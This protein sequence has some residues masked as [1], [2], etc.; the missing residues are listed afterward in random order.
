V[1]PPIIRASEEKPVP[2]VY[3]VNFASARVSFKRPERARLRKLLEQLL[4]EVRSAWPPAATKPRPFLLLTRGADPRA[5][6]AVE[7]KGSPN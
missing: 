3:V 7:L 1:S 4:R 5:N 6:P 2:Q